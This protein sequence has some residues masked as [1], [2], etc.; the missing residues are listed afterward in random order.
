MLEREN[1]DEYF[2]KCFYDFVDRNG[3]YADRIGNFFH[4]KQAINRNP[5]QVPDK[6]WGRLITNHINKFNYN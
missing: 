5:E 2:W 3:P 4:A 6:M 1:F